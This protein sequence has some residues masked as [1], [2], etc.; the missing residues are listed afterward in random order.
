MKVWYLVYSLFLSVC[1]SVHLCDT[2][3]RYIKTAE[4][5]AI[6]YQAVYRPPFYFLT[7]KV[8]AKWRLGVYWMNS[9]EFSGRTKS[10]R[11]HGQ[12]SNHHRSV[13]LIHPHAH[14]P[15]Q[16]DTWR[17]FFFIPYLFSRYD[18]GAS[19]EKCLLLWHHVLSKIVI[20]R[21]FS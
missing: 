12:L 15:T 10:T 5:R 17:Y 19:S 18:V 11:V 13:A 1:P 6:N 4:H 9:T 16:C 14:R 20:I 8:V 21:T 3:V 7:W 2:R